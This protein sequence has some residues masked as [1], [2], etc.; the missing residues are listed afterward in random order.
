MGRKTSWQRQN[1]ASHAN[2]RQNHRSRK[3]LIQIWIQR[4]N[5]TITRVTFCK[6]KAIYTRKGSI[7]Q[8]MILKH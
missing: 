2:K 4:D 8:L 1:W 5:P 6:I 3:S 7:F